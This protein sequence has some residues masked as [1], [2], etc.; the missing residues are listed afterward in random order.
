MSPTLSP[1]KSF[2]LHRQDN[3]LTQL[4]HSRQKSHHDLTPTPASG[5]IRSE[6]SSACA[7]RA[8]SEPR[9]STWNLRYKAYPAYLYPA[10]PAV[11]ALTVPFPPELPRNY[12]NVHLNPNQLIKSTSVIPNKPTCPF[13]PP[14]RSR[15]H[16]A[17]H[18]PPG[19][20]IH[21]DSHRQQL[22]SR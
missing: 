14:V 16:I 7:F 11:Q 17:C 1:G 22:A 3:S 10:S 18:V 4:D 12:S 8:L 15:Y 21:R 19:S 20:I 13:G 5:A 6:Q 2:R 9:T